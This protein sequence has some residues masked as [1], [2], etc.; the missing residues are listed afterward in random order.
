MPQLRCRESQ[1]TLAHNHKRLLLQAVVR[2]HTNCVH[3]ARTM[4]S[5]LRSISGAAVLVF[6]WVG[7]SAYGQ[8]IEPRTTVF[9]LF[10]SV[11][12]RKYNSTRSVPAW[13]R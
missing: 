5:R 12:K 13:S 9:T 7:T 6:L 11:K 4:I 2:W 3:S 8:T 1:N 10:E